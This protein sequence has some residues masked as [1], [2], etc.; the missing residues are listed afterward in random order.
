MLTL[1]EGLDD[2]SEV[3]ESEIGDG[4]FIEAREDAAES[5]ESAEQPLDLVALAVHGFAVLPGPQA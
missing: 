3:E 2:Q 5:F 1:T 4:E